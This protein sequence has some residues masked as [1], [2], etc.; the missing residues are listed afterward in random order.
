MQNFALVSTA[1]QRYIESEPMAWSSILVQVA[2]IAVFEVHGEESHSQV[3]AEGH[4]GCDRIG[5]GQVRPPDGFVFPA[6]EYVKDGNQDLVSI[7]QVIVG[8]VLRFHLGE[9]PGI[10]ADRR[11]PA[12]RPA[13]LPFFLRT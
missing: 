2:A 11:I 5:A 10:A 13:F 3:D 8:R 7:L 1:A 12:E 9:A 6:D 4:A